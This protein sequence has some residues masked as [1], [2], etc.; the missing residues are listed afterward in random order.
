[1]AD[2][3]ASLEERSQTDDW[4]ALAW[5]YA[6]TANRGEVNR[7]L[8]RHSEVQKGFMIVPGAAGA[9]HTAWKLQEHR[10]YAWLVGD[11]E[12][13]AFVTRSQHPEP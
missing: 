4:D 12:F 9:S 13:D 5:Y 10:D 6:L 11:P 7:L 3:A 2:K 8:R 1:M